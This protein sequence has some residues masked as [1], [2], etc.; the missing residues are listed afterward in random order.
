MSIE[1]FPI[2][3]DSK[4]DN[5]YILLLNGEKYYTS[6]LCDSFPSRVKQLH[7]YQ[8][9]GKELKDHCSHVSDIKEYGTVEELFDHLNHDLCKK[10]MVQ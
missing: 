7:W 3:P 6:N 5:I 10:M 9:F 2:I 1:N 4:E 8:E